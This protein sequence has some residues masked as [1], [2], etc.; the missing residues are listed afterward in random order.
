M[1]FGNIIRSA[2]SPSSSPSGIGGD[3][4]TIWHCDYNSDKIYELDTSDFSVTRSASSPSSSPYGIGGDANT[5]WY[6]D[7]SSDKIYELDADIP[8]TFIPQMILT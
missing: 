5:I 6:C 7:Y 2:S 1:A 4:N 8:I 3:A